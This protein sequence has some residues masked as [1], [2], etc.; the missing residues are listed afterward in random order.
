[1]QTDVEIRALATRLMRQMIEG[2]RSEALD[3]L[4]DAVRGRKWALKV[5]RRT[6]EIRSLHADE[7]SDFIPGYLLEMEHMVTKLAVL[8]LHSRQLIEQLDAICEARGGQGVGNS[9]FVRQVDEMQENI[10][11]KMKV[12]LGH[13][14]EKAAEMRRRIQTLRTSATR[15]ATEGPMPTDLPKELLDEAILAFMYARDEMA[16]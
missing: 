2:D 5:Q 16:A 6:D 3:A 9:A 11:A 12:L 8:K 15:P 7:L 10:A 4:A 14:D 13:I 1:M